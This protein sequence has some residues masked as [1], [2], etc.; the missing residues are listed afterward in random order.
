MCGN[1]PPR[2]R[3]FGLLLLAGLPWIRGTWIDLR[4]LPSAKAH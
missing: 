1:I 2:I 3:L 4:E